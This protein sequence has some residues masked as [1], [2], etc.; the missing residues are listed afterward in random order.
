MELFV[1]P[2]TLYV[3]RTIVWRA[4]RVTYSKQHRED[5][6]NFIDI[7]SMTLALRLFQVGCILQSQ[8]RICRIFSRF[9]VD[10]V[11]TLYCSSTTNET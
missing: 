4:V 7:R 2:S 8:H 6:Q 10:N 3:F 11:A 5:E 9:I 1:Y